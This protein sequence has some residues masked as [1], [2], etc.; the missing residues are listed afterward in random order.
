METFLSAVDRLR[1]NLQAWRI[2]DSLYEGCSA[3]SVRLITKGAL[4]HGSYFVLACG[5]L[6][7]RGTNQECLLQRHSRSR[8]DYVFRGETAS[9]NK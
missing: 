3:A 2:K 8:L 5:E 7:A 9:D 1:L 4:D 6:F